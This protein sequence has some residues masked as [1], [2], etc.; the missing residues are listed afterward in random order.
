MFIMPIR[1]RFFP[2]VNFSKAK[3]ACK[4]FLRFHVR[5]FRDKVITETF[6][7]HSVKNARQAHN[8]DA[9]AGV[10]ISK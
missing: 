2:H 8:T 5:P 3:T 7:T 10:L 1:P 4:S 6:G 9:L